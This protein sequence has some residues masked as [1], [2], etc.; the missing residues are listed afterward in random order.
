MASKFNDIWTKLG[1]KVGANTGKAKVELPAAQLKA[2]AGK[3]DF[4]K[5]VTEAQIQAITAGGQDA[6]SALLEIVNHVGR[7]SFETA[8][9][10]N[11]NMVQDALSRQADIHNGQIAEHIKAAQLGTN[12]SRDLPG[13]DSPMAR[14]LIE[15]IRAGVLA[16][17]PG[18]TADEL[19]AETKELLMEFAG[20]IQ[21]KV[22]EQSANAAIDHDAWLGLPPLVATTA[23]AAAA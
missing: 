17:N 9:A 20:V 1:E 13:L 5:G 19:T 11:A 3:L 7:T 15:T 8:M 18:A 6:A 4:A 23:A 2:V 10:A 12:I 14:P 22:E 16:N 21:P